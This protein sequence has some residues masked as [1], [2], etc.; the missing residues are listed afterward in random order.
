M[1]PP[2]LN[3]QPKESIMKSRASWLIALAAVAGLCVGGWT[4]TG[5]QR[6]QRGQW[7]Y[8]ELSVP[9]TLPAS[10]SGSMSVI[11]VDRM[12]EQGWELV[13]VLDRGNGTKAYYFKRAR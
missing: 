3:H 12:G 10:R 9:D 4:A 1:M 6:P 5:Q 8:L 11:A 13:S 2:P 7:E